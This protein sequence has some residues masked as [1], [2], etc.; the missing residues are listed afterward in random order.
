MT[1]ENK[2]SQS[3]S[4][5]ESSYDS[6]WEKLRKQVN[7]GEICISKAPRAVRIVEGL[8]FIEISLHDADTKEFICSLHGNLFDSFFT[9][10]AKLKI[11]KA[12]LDCAKLER[13]VIFRS[14]HEILNFR[15]IQKLFLDGRTVEKLNF[16]FGFVIPGSTNSW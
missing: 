5:S 6:E 10:E 9:K 14:V 11:P 13:K 1:S 3:E 8:Q 12:V 4:Y 16:H 7:Q 15:M 2:L